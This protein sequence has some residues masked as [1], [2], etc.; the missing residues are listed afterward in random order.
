VELDRDSS[1]LRRALPSS[2]GYAYDRDPERPDWY[3]VFP[4]QRFAE[5][6]RT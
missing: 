6:W 2:G 1:P 3:S 4:E 5:P